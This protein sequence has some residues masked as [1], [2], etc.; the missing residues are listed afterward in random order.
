MNN[1]K[2]WLDLFIEEKELNRDH[3]FQVTG[4]S[5]INYISLDVVIENIKITTEKEQQAIK[6]QI[7]KIDFYNGDVLHY[8]KHLATAI[9]I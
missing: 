8:F 9:A 5:G 1:F 4:D 2:K 3:I 7:I 6:K